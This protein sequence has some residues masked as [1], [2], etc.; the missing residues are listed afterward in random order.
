[1]KYSVGRTDLSGGIYV[2]ADEYE[3]KEMKDK[4][5]ECHKKFIDI[6]IVIE[7]ME[8]I[9]YCNKNECTVIETYNEEKDLEKLTGDL[10]F[11]TLKPGYFAVFY[12]HDAH[13]PGLR[14][15]NKIQSTIRKMVMKLPVSD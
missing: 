14:I 11:I 10:D 6:H 1:M 9:G 13:M 15:Y 5:I 8:Q 2:N 12:P 3:L 4:F 7:G